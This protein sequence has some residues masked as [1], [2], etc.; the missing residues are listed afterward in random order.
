MWRIFRKRYSGFDHW[1]LLFFALYAAQIVTVTS[2]RYRLLMLPPVFLFAAAGAVAFEWRRFWYLPLIIVFV[3][4]MFTVTDYGGLRCETAS[5]YAE[6]AFRRGDYRQAD[7]LAAYV[8]HSPLDPDPVRM[9][10]LR[11]AAAE[12][13][14][15]LARAEKHY[16][17]AAEL[18]PETPQAWMNLA[19]LA[20]AAGDVGRADGLYRR[21]LE[22][23]PRSPQLLY[24]YARFRFGAK[25]ECD[26]EIAAALEADPAGSAVWNLAG[27]AAMRRGDFRRAA[28]CFGNA[29]RFSSGEMRDRYL[30]NRRIALESRR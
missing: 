10:N 9:A 29:A 23:A 20:A 4:A 1:L 3:C 15:D 19:N 22:L 5:L 27:L 11:G 24:N 7:E 30:N 25:A 8:E 14:G 26:A 6:I 13:T 21:A 12:R 2:G 16:R 17:R 28:D 18:E